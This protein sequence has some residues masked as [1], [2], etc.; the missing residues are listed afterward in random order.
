MSSIVA[1]QIPVGVPPGGSFMAIGPGNVQMMVVNPGVPAGTIIHV[2]APPPPAVV[3]MMV[4]ASPT[5]AAPQPPQ[6]ERQASVEVIKE[7]DI[8]KDAKIETA[9]VPAYQKTTLAEAP[10]QEELCPFLA[11][12][13]V[14]YSCYPVFPD[15]IGLYAKGVA[16]ACLEMEQVCCKVSKTEGTY[17]KIC[18]G[19]LE[20]VAPVSCCKLAF[21]FC[22]L[23]ARW[24]IPT[25]GEVPC[26]MSA[27]GFICVKSFKCVCNLYSTADGQSQAKV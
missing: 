3:P 2:R 26:Q 7:E 9:V 18:N 12:C 5:P 8:P 16:C 19:E 10:K 11:C 6:M 22:C 13:C 25:D 1:V 15:C 27:C 14:A 4:G 21:T 17:C 20:V 24:A 23:D